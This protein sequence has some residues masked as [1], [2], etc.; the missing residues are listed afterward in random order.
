[1]GLFKI[2]KNFKPDIIF[3]NNEPWSLTAF[4]VVLFRKILKLKSKLIIYTCENQIRQ[5]PFPF[6]IIDKYVLK[7]TNLVLKIYK[8]KYKFQ[9]KCTWHK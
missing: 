1:L 6:N 8:K 3:V 5:Y 9:K 7:N 2:L 4:E